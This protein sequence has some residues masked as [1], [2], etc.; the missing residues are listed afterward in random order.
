LPPDHHEVL[1]QKL[2]E[3]TDQVRFA[4]K[5]ADPDELMLLVEKQ[6]TVA[7]DLSQA[8]I[9]TDSRLLDRILALNLQVSDVIKE[10]QKCQHDLSTRIKQVSDGRKLIHAYVT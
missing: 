9:C 2:S 8:G 7:R 4:L 6:D 1:Y 10:I 5:E 3:I